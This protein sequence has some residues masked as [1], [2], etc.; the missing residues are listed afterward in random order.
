MRASG[1]LIEVTDV[2][3]GWQLVTRYTVEVEGSAK[4]AVVADAVPRLLTHASS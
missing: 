4:P 3:G 1:E 2:G